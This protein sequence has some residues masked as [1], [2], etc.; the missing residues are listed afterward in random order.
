MSLTI[1]LTPEMEAKINWNAK[2]RGISPT[3]LARQLIETAP[4]PS[5][6]PSDSL[7]ETAEEAEGPTLWELHHEFLEAMWARHPDGPTTN[8]ALLEEAC[9]VPEEKQA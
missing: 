6:P 9:D 2:R 8:Y 7:P 1:D 3:D 4:L 5:L